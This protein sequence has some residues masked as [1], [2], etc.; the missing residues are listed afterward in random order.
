MLCSLE[1][2]AQIDLYFD[3]EARFSMQPCLP[4]VWQAQDNQIRIFPQREEKLNLFG[5]FRA[6]NV[7]VTRSNEGKH[8]F[9]VFD[10]RH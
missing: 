4:R 7:A 6:D 10:F 8:Q 3:D 1:A 9:P 2:T 5:I